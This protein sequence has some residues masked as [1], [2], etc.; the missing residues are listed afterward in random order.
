[1][2]RKSFQELSKN[3][4]NEVDSEEL[5]IRFPSVESALAFKTWL[6]DHGEGMYWEW[7]D[8]YESQTGERVAVRFDY[9]SDGSVISSELIGPDAG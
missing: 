3:R 8:D 4:F 6:C 7:A 9:W 1:M 5:V 2:P